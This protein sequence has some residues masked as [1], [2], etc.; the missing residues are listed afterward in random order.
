MLTL[1]IPW[2]PKQREIPFKNEQ[3]LCP[4]PSFQ[5]YS[6]CNFRSSRNGNGPH[7]LTKELIFTYCLE[8]QDMRAK[9]LQS[10]PTLCNPM[11]CSLPGSSVHGILQA[12]LEWVAVLSSR[13]SSQPRDQ[14]CISY[15][16]CIG[17]Q[18]LYH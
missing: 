12:R 14:T 10:C 7:W 11:D 8:I 5:T 3:K 18:V 9:L 13:G 15:F 1:V 2:R 17:R 16:S 6:E 4:K